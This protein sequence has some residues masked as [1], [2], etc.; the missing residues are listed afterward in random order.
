MAASK[1][2]IGFEKPAVL[3]LNEVAPHLSTFTGTATVQRDVVELYVIESGSTSNLTLTTDDFIV[4]TLPR[5]QVM[6]G[7]VILVHLS[8]DHASNGD[9]PA[10]ASRPSASSSTPASCGGWCAAPRRS[11]RS[12][13]GGGGNRTRR[14]RLPVRALQ[15][16]R[17]RFP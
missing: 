3:R 6:A 5:V 12:V 9:A 16:G 2:F 13:T 11:A 4:A 14:R 17:K 1:A 10:S 8:P 7:D 15:R